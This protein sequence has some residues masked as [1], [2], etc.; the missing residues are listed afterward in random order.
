MDA[1]VQYPAVASA[2]LATCRAALFQDDDPQ[3][4]ARV[5]MA[6]LSGYCTAYDPGADYADVI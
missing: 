3:R 2:R 5:S 4:A 1:A 6:Q